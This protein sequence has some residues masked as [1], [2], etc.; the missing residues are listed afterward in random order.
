MYYLLY[1]AMGD[2]VTT[3]PIESEVQMFLLRDISVMTNV[4]K[5]Q[6]TCQHLVSEERADHFIIL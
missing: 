4:V 2:D 1:L 3:I 5:L 6:S